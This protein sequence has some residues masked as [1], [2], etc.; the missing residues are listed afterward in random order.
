MGLSKDRS[1]WGE[2]IALVAT[3]NL[4]GFVQPRGKAHGERRW[5]RRKALA[6]ATKTAPLNG[7]QQLRHY[8][9]LHFSFVIFVARV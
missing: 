7:P 1:Y 6:V 3:K 4:F 9:T 8:S 5:S 2:E